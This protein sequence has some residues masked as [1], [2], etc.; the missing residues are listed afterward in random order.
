MSFEFSTALSGAL[1]E[2]VFEHTVGSL[3]DAFVARARSLR[4]PAT[5][6]A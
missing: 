2:P 3:V 4:Q 1:L 5:G 6:P